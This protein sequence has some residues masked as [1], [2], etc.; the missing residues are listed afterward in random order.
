MSLN[1]NKNTN[2]SY[3]EKKDK[4]KK[5]MGHGIK[6]RVRCQPSPPGNLKPCFIDAGSPNNKISQPLM[7]LKKILKRLGLPR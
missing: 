7:C 4:S 5:E 3:F 6:Q 2:D 1:Y